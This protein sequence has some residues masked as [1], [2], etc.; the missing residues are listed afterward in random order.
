MSTLVEQAVV[1][2]DEVRDTF[3]KGHV[4]LLGATF[5]I[6]LVRVSIIDGCIDVYDKSDDLVSNIFNMM[7]SYHDGVYETI[8]IPGREG[9]W[10]MF[11]FPFCT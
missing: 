10:V 7:Q 6:V 4:V 11:I 5:H 8:T 9:D 2:A 1:S 3:L